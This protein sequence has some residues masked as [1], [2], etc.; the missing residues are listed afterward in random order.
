MTCANESTNTHCDLI[1]PPSQVAE[2]RESD[3]KTASITSPTGGAECP[4]STVGYALFL[5]LYYHRYLSNN[6]LHGTLPPSWHR[7]THLS[8]LGMEHNRLSGAI[9]AGCHPQPII[10]IIIIFSDNVVCQHGEDESSFE[11]VVR[12]SFIITFSQV[13]ISESK[14]SSLDSLIRVKSLNPVTLGGTGYLEQSRQPWAHLPSWNGC[15][16]TRTVYLVSRYST[17]LLKVL[18]IR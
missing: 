4:V 17:I 9:L 2:E 12:V 5:K 3:W 6:N 13:F 11:C 14:C 16:V 7:L 1:Y 8:L 10:I 15:S 18:W